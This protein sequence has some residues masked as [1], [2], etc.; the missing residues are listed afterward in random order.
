MCEIR[1]RS[2]FRE[3]ATDFQVLDAI[4][5]FEESKYA[6][7]STLD[8]LHHTPISSECSS[9]AVENRECCGDF[10]RTR[11]GWRRPSTLSAWI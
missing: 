2:Y 10:A 8:L 11:V 6:Y 5:T 3:R 1:F 4:T 9:R 7:Q